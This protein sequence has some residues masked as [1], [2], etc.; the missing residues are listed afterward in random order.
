MPKKDAS[1]ILDES[2]KKQLTE[3]DMAIRDA[4]AGYEH[5]KL[6]WLCSSRDRMLATRGRES[7]TQKWN[8]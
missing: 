3:R 5:L 6:R 1:I 8:L 4:E 2:C 7:L